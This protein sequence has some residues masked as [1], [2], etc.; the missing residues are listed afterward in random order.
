VTKQK[1]GEIKSDIVLVTYFR[2]KDSLSRVIW[3]V[4]NVTY[5]KCLHLLKLHILFQDQVC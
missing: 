4:H 5:L 1:K 2:Y 3:E